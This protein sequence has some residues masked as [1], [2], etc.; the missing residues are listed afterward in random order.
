MLDWLACQLLAPRLVDLTQVPTPPLPEP[1]VDNDL[2]TRAR[3]THEE[4]DALEWQARGPINPYKLL[5]GMGCRDLTTREADQQPDTAGRAPNYAPYPAFQP[6]EIPL[7]GGPVLTGHHS[8]GAPGAPVVMVIHGL[9]DSH[10]TGYVV[11][12][13]EVL[14]RMGFHVVALDLR[15]HGRQLGR[16]LPPSLGIEEGRDLFAA[17][18][19]LSHAEGVSVGIVGMS[20]GAHCA[21]RAAHEATLAGEPEVLR[22]GVLALCGPLD[23]HEAILGFDD[24]GRLPG[25]D[26]FM[27]RMIFSELMKVLD[28]FLRL[29]TRG[30]A[31]PRADAY[32]VYVEQVLLPAY[33]EMP[34]EFDAFLDEARS[35]Q[36]AVMGKLAVPTAIVHPVDDPLVPVTHARRAREAAGDNPYVHVRELTFGGHIGL[37]GVD[38][39][40]TQQLLATWFGRLRDG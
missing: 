13:A 35:S 30:V 10:V 7:D 25:A 22:G 37:A 29:R 18:R 21:V 23:I 31:L 28:R 38:G 5:M 33:P 11:E 17:A 14:R 8:T 20:Y 27:D 26:A 19:T 6:L 36:P 1:W 12:Y 34:G 40:A 16:G 4:L 2:L 9:F 15:D 39:A 24:H 32:R 3:R